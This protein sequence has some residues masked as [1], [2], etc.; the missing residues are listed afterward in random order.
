MEDEYGGSAKKWKDFSSSGWLP[1][2][3]LGVFVNG[4]IVSLRTPD[5]FD[6]ELGE[7][8][9]YDDLARKWE[10]K[11]LR[12]EIAVTPLECALDELR[13]GYRVLEA[14][15]AG[16]DEARLLTT[17]RRGGR[18]VVTTA[19]AEAGAELFRDAP[20]LVV[21][22]AAAETTS[23]RW[24]AFNEL[25]RRAR[26]VAGNGAA[27]AALEALEALPVD[28]PAEAPG[29][30]GTCGFCGARRDRAKL[31]RCGK[32][33]TA[34]FCGRDCFRKAWKA[35]HRETCGTMEVDAFHAG[36]RRWVAAAGVVEENLRAAGRR[37]ANDAIKAEMVAKV[38]DCYA[39]FDAAVAG[40]PPLPGHRDALC[41]FAA[42]LDHACAPTAR[43][44]WDRETLVCEAARDVPAGE[45]LTLN[46][47]PRS[48]PTWGV[49][50]RRQWLRDHRH[51]DCAC[52]TCAADLAAKAR[53]DLA[54][55]PP[56]PPPPALEP[57]A[58]AFDISPPL[59]PE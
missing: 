29:A 49:D 6:G 22:A 58:G 18:T 33:K 4:S 31:L 57:S 20:T 16:V 55:P 40:L 50:T 8:V 45:E 1:S 7:V 3:E 23:M 32:C 25:K 26:V 17:N 35:G 12:G 59:P 30:A 56:P 41:L 38:N 14:N 47:G 36:A 11:L 51:F 13:F 24:K 48:L 43:V 5:S 2:D 53:D 21:T 42:R 39:R 34:G 46:Y 27:K 44:R 37:P 28:R 10:V 9:S 15:A 54:A 19:A 52:A